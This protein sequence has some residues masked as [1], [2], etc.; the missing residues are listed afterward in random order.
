MSTF[1]NTTQNMT[2]ARPNSSNTAVTY[3]IVACF[4]V[5]LCIFGLLGNAIVSWILVFKIKRTKYT[6]Y[7]L[8]LALADF[9]YLFFVAIV[10]LLMVDQMLNFRTQTKMTLTAL[11]IMYDFG[12]LSG[13]FFLTAIS[14]ERCLSVL[15]PIWYKCHRPKRLSTITCIGI[16]LLGIL[17]SLIDNLVCPSASF[18]KGTQ[19]CTSVQIFT[20]FLTFAL[21]IPLMLMS[22]FTLIYVIKTTSK[23]C[24]PPK[25]YIA[26]I[27][28]VLVFLIS[29]V[30]IRLLWILLYFKV[31]ASN[32]YYVALFFSST[33]CTVFNSM[34]NPF[35]YFFVGRQRKRK[36]W[37][38]INEALSRV[39][40][41]DDTECSNGSYGSTT[42]TNL[43]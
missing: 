18:M 22:S 7:I 9:L 11:E 35:I 4:A 20:S 40:K 21:V 5:I 32:V 12:Y 14:V 29:V 10:M 37:G 1:D 25:I 42:V 27:I 13:M 17:L 19:E 26:I 30:P 8:N 23:K 28:T 2:T 36:F 38:S 24:R 31:L 34:A 6:V 33:Y 15:F 39:F 16:W 3:S 41:D 43:G